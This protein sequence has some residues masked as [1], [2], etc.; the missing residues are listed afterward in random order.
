MI[1]SSRTFA[2]LVT[3]LSPQKAAAAVI[4]YRL[5]KIL[6]RKQYR[7]ERIYRANMYR[8][9][10]D[11]QFRRRRSVHVTIFTPSEM[12]IA[13]GLSPLPLESVGGV[14][15]SLGVAPAVL[16][17]I[18]EAGVPGSLCTFHR[19]HLSLVLHNGFPRPRCVF[20]VSAPCDGNIRAFQT[21]SRHLSCPSFY[22]DV[23]SPN[24]RGAEA[25]LKE[26]LSDCFHRLASDIKIKQPMARLKR[27]LTVAEET[28]KCIQSVS[29][30]RR[31]MYLPGLPLG[32]TWNFVLHFSQ[33]GD[34]RTLHFY[35]VLHHELVTRG[36]P[37]P[38][39]RVRLL[40]MHLV[41]TYKSHVLDVLE[42][43]SACVVME[44]YNAVD[45]PKL[46]VT[47]PFGSIARKMLSQPQLGGP[48]ER[49]N[50]MNDLVA[51]FSAAGILHFSHWGC[52]QSSGAI[53]VLGSRLHVPFLNIDADLVNHE[54]ESGGQ[55]ATRIAAFMEMIRGRQASTRQA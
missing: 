47:D 24:D 40:L 8:K 19:S 2:S 43:N 34:P 53:N 13:L 42:E 31:H 3:P 4:L 10:F 32:F 51:R 52:R 26:Q 25:Y 9:F 39:D 15:G 7:H 11:A 54:N 22:V 14:L 20:A 6:D 23:P 48:K 41:P 45:W 21:L 38:Q 35:R 16:R 50:L 29:E 33:L 5:L 12:L 36:Q 55:A 28:R 44:E 37:V 1:G 17:G 49:I 30:I 18:Q 46:D 27:S